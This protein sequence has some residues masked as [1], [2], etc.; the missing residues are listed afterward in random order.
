MNIFEIFSK[1]FEIVDNPFKSSKLLDGD[2]FA[3]GWCL[4]PEQAVARR[5]NAMCIISDIES[6]SLNSEF[7]GERYNVPF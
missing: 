2:S 4:W 3:L 6:K 1:I 5:T 7:L